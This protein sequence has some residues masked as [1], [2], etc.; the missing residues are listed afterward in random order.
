MDRYEL[1][2]LEVL[3]LIAGSEEPKLTAL[4][5]RRRWRYILGLAVAAK[6]GI[7]LDNSLP[8][9]VIECDHYLVKA[10]RIVAVIDEWLAE[11]SEQPVS[12]AR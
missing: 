1:D 8:Q 9:I 5:V 4:Q 3:M 10:E 11:H 7:T 2:E 12:D 6:Q